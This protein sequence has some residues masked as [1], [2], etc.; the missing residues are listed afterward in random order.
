MTVRF[1]TGLRDSIL[2]SDGLRTA[3]A[4]GVIRVY[5]GAQPP[6]A[7]SA[8]TGTLL[9]E[10][11]ESGGAFT[12]GNPANGLNFDAPTNGLLSKAAAETWTG[13]GLADGNA[14][15]CRFSGNPLDDGGASTT[16][17]RIDATIAKTGGDVSISNSAIVSGQPNSVDVY[18]IEMR[19]S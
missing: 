10:I 5:S 15:W 6:T 7:D 2:D 13:S 17:A 16:L 8:A 12:H 11:T 18:Q 3:M 9:L 4:N 1:S 14:G 19:E